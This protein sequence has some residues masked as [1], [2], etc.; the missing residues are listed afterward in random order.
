MKKQVAI[1]EKQILGNNRDIV[2]KSRSEYN[3]FVY[4][5]KLMIL[6]ALNSLLRLYTVSAETDK[7]QFLVE[8]V[9][10]GVIVV[11]AA[12]AELKV[13]PEG[14]L[15]AEKKFYTALAGIE[16]LPEMVLESNMGLFN[17]MIE[18]SSDNERDGT[19][20]NTGF[21]NETTFDSGYYEKLF[22]VAEDE[23]D[24]KN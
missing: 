18:V 5:H 24:L 4:S 1:R 13:L 3:T 16:C 12:I 17:F 8:E 9:M 20:L 15:D 21:V 11:K 19:A 2:D 10:H 7:V 14:S 22:N 23:K 6:T